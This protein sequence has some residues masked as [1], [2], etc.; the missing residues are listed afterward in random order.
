MAFLKH[1]MNQKT[2]FFSLLTLL[3][4]FFICVWLF[5]IPYENLLLYINHF[6]PDKPYQFFTSQYH[7]YF[8]VFLAL[9]SFSIVLLFS[10]LQIK[11]KQY[12]KFVKT[13]K[14]EVLLL[15]DKTKA[16]TIQFLRTEDRPYL[17]LLFFVFSIGII[18]RLFYLDRPIFHDE[19]KTIYS[20]VSKSWV[21]TISN[22]YVPNN[23][24]FHS[25][26]SRICYLIVGNEEW[27][28][29][30]PVFFSG[31][32][33]LVLCY[34]YARSFFNKHVAI[35]LLALITNGIPLVSYSV[36]ARG[37]ILIT[38]CFLLLLLMIKEL[39]KNRGNIILYFLFVFISSIGLWTAPVMVMPLFF[40]FYWFLLD[41]GRQ[42]LFYRMKTSFVTLLF[43]GFTAFLLYSPIIVRC[44]INALI[45][46][47]YVKEQTF[48]T[49][50]EQFPSYF[51]LYWNFLTS[52]YSPSIKYV[53]MS[54]FVLGVLYHC[55]SKHG[56][57]LFIS[58][59]LSAFSTF[60][61]LKRLPFDRTIL[62]VYPIFWTFNASGAY[63]ILKFISN[64]TGQDIKT[65][66]LSFSVIAFF[67]TS[68][69]C[70]KSN[71][72]IESYVNQ[73][74]VE[75]EIIV[76]DI[77]KHLTE[78]NK[79]ETS[80]PLA[81]PIRYYLLKKGLGENILHWHNKGKDKGPLLNSNKVYII[82]R[83]GRNSLSSYGYNDSFSII[84]F[85]KPK[86]WRKYQNTV[87]VYV[88]EKL[89]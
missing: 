12:L 75:A 16:K 28:F 73:T 7:F 86:L 68:I 1:L 4:A 49:I 36:N 25:V 85:S 47:P 6:R 18:T 71:G 44:G 9:I 66:C 61:I 81:G 76:S 46:N 34:L 17:Y 23:H 52:G 72:T 48:K 42:N 63:Y 65:A 39:S 33:T 38:G 51:V 14:K 89:L 31:C 58:L 45:S 79:I 27:V 43:I 13:L 57:N 41:G 32:C 35:I 54:L 40:V 60:F 69:M 87:E 15:I 5:F 29:R 2:Y 8:R 26:L 21:D 50:L 56:R 84:G 30:L 53:L 82:T 74:C 19:A 3:F 59:V 22:Y 78:G 70:L 11:T 64:K 88:I 80:T 24:V 62:F 37:Y 20:F 10:L 55:S 67:Y 83:S 77:Q